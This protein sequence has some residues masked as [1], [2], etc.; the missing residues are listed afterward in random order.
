MFNQE[1]WAVGN[2]EKTLFVAYKEVD[3][4]LNYPRG[5]RIV[6]QRYPT[7]GTGWGWWTGELEQ[8]RTLPLTSNAWFPLEILLLEPHW[9]VLTPS[10]LPLWFEQEGMKDVAPWSPVTSVPWEDTRGSDQ[11][12]AHDSI[13]GRVAGASDKTFILTWC[14]HNTFTPA[15]EEQ[16]VSDQA[17][18]QLVLNY[19]IQLFFIFFLIVTQKSW[20]WMCKEQWSAIYLIMKPSQQ[21]TVSWG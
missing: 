11:S 15:V 13:S 2:A 10:C 9:V 18:S 1:K 17:P 5:L 19:I 7:E 12:W 14:L 6:H 21:K 16:L 4:E 8:G 3:I 20:D